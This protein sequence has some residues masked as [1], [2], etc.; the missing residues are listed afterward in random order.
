M[1]AQISVS[2]RGSAGT[3][4]A[5]LLSL[6]W[7]LL[8]ALPASAATYVVTKFIESRDGT[9]DADCSLREAVIEANANP[10]TDTILLP[11]GTYIVRYRGR[12][13]NALLGDLDLLE[14]TIIRGVGASRTVI[15]SSLSTD[16]AFQVH[17][18][19]VVEITDLTLLDCDGGWFE[20]SGCINSL[21]DLTLRRF[22]IINGGSG[23]GA[24]VRAR[25]GSLTIDSCTFSGNMSFES[26]GTIS[27]EVETT[28]TNT[29]ISGGEAGNG[30]GGGIHALS[31]ANVTINNTTITD[32]AATTGGGGVRV[33]PGA[34]VTMSHSVLA[35][36]FDSGGTA[37]DCSGTFVSLGFNLIGNGTG[38]T[39]FSALKG[40]QIG[41]SPSPLNPL[42]T[43]LRMN[44]G[45]LLTQFPRA[46]SPLIDR[47]SSAIPGGDEVACEV[48]DER[49]SARP[50]DGDGNGSSICDIGAVEAGARFLFAD[51]FESGDAGAWDGSNP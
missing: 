20:N 32:N 26:G 27:T 4:A 28:I 35:G 48:L 21:G 18:A 2:A 45:R 30:A 46:G 37:P 7:V 24:A 5:F 1:K 12:E 17:P 31:G 29:T 13:D 49:G 23:A 8:T 47:G 38:C 44:G 11:A 25:S 16:S 42:L 36:N 10:G 9:C 34:T 41:T 15:E 3:A 19:T 39:G 51:G 22:Q 40:D 50:F 33:D 43:P 6:G 14:D